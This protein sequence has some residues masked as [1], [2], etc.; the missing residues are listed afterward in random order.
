MKRR[1]KNLTDRDGNPAKILTARYLFKL[2]KDTYSDLLVEI[3][4]NF[5]LS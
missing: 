3:L 5:M 4:D 2:E 1:L